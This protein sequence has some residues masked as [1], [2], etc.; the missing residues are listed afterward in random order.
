MKTLIVAATQQEAASLPR[1][2]P[3]VA[4]VLICGAGKAAAAASL[5]AALAAWP[6][7][8]RKHLRVL[9]VGTAGALRDDV[10]GVVRPST[11]WAWDFAAAAIRSLGVPAIDELSLVDGDGAVLASG[12]TFVADD[13]VRARLAPRAAVVDME[14]FALAAAC[15]VV[16]VPCSAVKWVSDRA[17]ADAARSWSVMVGHGARILG[18]VTEELLDGG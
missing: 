9:N 13:A 1:G 14:A 3:S 4:G 16:G 2:H 17:D 7:G 11:V 18:E 6:T 15:R 10:A 8:E 5:A 12:D